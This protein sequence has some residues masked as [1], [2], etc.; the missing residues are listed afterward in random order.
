MFSSG[1]PRVLK[2]QVCALSSQISKIYVWLQKNVRRK[3]WK[4]IWFHITASFFTKQV[5]HHNNNFS[6]VSQVRAMQA[7]QLPLHV[8]SKWLWLWGTWARTNISLTEVQQAR[9]EGNAGRTYGHDKESTPPLKFHLSQN[10]LIKHVFWGKNSFYLG[11]WSHPQLCLGPVISENESFSE[12]LRSA[13]K[14]MS[15]Y[16]VIQLPPYV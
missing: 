5:W 14:L 7:W 1:V 6:F 13:G 9:V 8:I 16:K 3:L 2:K 4:K 10:H 15:L 12:P 11:A